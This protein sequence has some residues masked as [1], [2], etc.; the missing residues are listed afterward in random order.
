MVMAVADCC[1]MCDAVDG[2]WLLIVAAGCCFC[3]LLTFV[4]KLLLL[5][6]AECCWLLIVAA[7]AGCL[8]MMAV[9]RCWLVDS[10]LLTDG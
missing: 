7:V 10:W 8:L 1:L 6:A 2:G 4:E 9:A 3:L 5:L